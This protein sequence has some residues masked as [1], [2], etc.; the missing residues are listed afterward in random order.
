MLNWVKHSFFLWLS[1]KLRL[2]CL[3]TFPKYLENWKVSTEEK[4]ALISINLKYFDCLSHGL[5]NGA[6]IIFKILFYFFD[7]HHQ[8]EIREWSIVWLHAKWTFLIHRTTATSVDHWVSK[9]SGL[10]N[11]LKKVFLETTFNNCL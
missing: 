4:K 6:K 5:Y 11:Q 8:I 10:S 1:L 2:S 3:A 9:M 7:C